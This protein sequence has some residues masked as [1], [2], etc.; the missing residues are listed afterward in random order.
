[1]VYHPTGKSLRLNLYSYFMP[2]PMAVWLFDS[3]MIGDK[4][5]HLLIP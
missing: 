4:N 5:L 3:R 2:E 1:M